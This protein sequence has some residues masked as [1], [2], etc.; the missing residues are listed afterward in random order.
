MRIDLAVLDRQFELHRAE[1]EGAAL[2][3]LRS[4]RYI[5]GPELEAFEREFA[6]FT[7]AKYC[8][9]LNSGLDALTLSVRALGIGAGDEVVVPANTYIATVLAVTEN[10]ATPVF[11]EPDA[12]YNLDTERLAAAVTPRT[13][14]VMPVH[15]Y[16]QAVHMPPVMEIAQRYGLAVI[17]D[18]AQSHGAHFGDTMTGRFGAIGCFSFYPTKNLGAFGDAGAIVT[19]DADLAEKIRML[20]NYGSREKYHN[21]LCGVNSRLDELQAALLRTKLKHLPALTAE[22]QAIAEKYL[23][24]IQN[25]RITLPQTRPGAEHVYH[26][27]VVRTAERDRLQAYLREHGID[28]VIHYPIP[29]HL[30]ECYR[31]L[32]HAHGDFPVTEQYADEVLSL[33]MFNGMRDDEIGYVIDTLNRFS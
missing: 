2:R 9:G 22:R 32:G 18:C 27:F 19:D 5:L 26:Q 29:P 11:I 3:A 30:A 13:R 8:V 17:E 23:A 31:S 20:R 21:E 10:G 4:G 14:A 7:G 15:L 25:D 24:G 6:A 12:Y 16:G 28:T 1:Y 33:P